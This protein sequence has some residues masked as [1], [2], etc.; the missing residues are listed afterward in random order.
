MKSVKKCDDNFSEEIDI[1]NIFR[2]LRDSYTMLKHIN[3][4]KNKKYIKYNKNN[5]I[6]FSGS[7][8]SSYSSSDESKNNYFLDH[9][10]EDVPE[11]AGDLNFKEAIEASIIRGLPFSPQRKGTLRKNK[12]KKDGKFELELTGTS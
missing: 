9:E 4:G 12:D 8:E 6:N 1:I 2:K 11:N 10:K 7:E 3:T 5:V